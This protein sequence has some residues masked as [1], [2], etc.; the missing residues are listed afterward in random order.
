MSG[1]TLK[2]SRPEAREIAWMCWDFLYQIAP[3]TTTKSPTFGDQNAP[4]KQL[5][6]KAFSRHTNRRRL[7]GPPAQ[8]NIG[9]GVA[10]QP[11][12]AA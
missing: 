6:F 4:H 11:R 1:P 7:S 9:V 8:Q 12:I 10:C 3:K 2:E 5:N